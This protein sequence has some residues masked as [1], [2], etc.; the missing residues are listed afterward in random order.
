M[1]I[2][3]LVRFASRDGPLNAQC[4]TPSVNEAPFPASKFHPEALCSFLQ[5]RD[6]PASEIIDAIMDFLTLNT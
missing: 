1:T 5:R 4:F 2:I 3:V 6:D